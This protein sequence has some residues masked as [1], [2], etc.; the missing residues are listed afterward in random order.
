MVEQIRIVASR[1]IQQRLRQCLAEAEGVN[2]RIYTN[3]DPEYV[4][5]GQKGRQEGR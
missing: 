5:Y 2:G 1:S 4:V 3:K